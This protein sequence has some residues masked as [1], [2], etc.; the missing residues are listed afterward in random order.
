M[1]A[2]VPS[3]QKTNVDIDKKNVCVCV[4]GSIFYLNLS[5]SLVLSFSLPGRDSSHHYERL[6]AFYSTPTGYFHSLPFEALIV[7]LPKPLGRISAGGRGVSAYQGKEFILFKRHIYVRHPL[8]TDHGHPKT[9]AYIVIL[10]MLFY[11]RNGVIF[12]HAS[13][14]QASVLSPISLR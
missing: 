3:Q 1:V 10:S 7:S 2:T 12:R 14:L 8:P 6:S 11:L 13:A 9:G 5:C 4:A